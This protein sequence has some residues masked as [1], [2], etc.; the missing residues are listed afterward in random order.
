MAACA[1]INRNCPRCVP[2]SPLRGAAPLPVLGKAG[3]VEDHDVKTAPICAEML[4]KLE[5]VL[6]QENVLAWIETV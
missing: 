2:G 1:R 3:G 5:A 6:D 4:Q